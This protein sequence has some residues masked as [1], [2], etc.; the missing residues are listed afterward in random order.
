MAEITQT[1]S[2]FLPEMPISHVQSS[3][4]PSAKSAFLPLTLAVR[5]GCPKQAKLSKIS[6]GYFEDKY[7]DRQISLRVTIIDGYLPIT[8]IAWS[9]PG[10][11]KQYTSA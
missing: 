5:M 9:S 10:S 6:G 7:I 8:Q 1:E 3:L 11:N 4:W 2:H